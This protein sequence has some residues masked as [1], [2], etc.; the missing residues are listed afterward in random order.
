[1]DVNFARYSVCPE[2]GIPASFITLFCSGAVTSPEN[3]PSIQPFTARSSPASSGLALAGS[4]VPQTKK[5]ASGS[6]STLR[7]LFAV[8]FP[9]ALRIVTST[10][11]WRALALRHSGSAITTTRVDHSVCASARHKSGP[12]PAGSPAVITR[13]LRVVDITI[14]SQVQMRF[15]LFYCQMRMSTNASSRIRRIQ[16]CSSSDTLL[17]LMR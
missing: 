16:S 9:S 8:H 12:I 4:G 13:G 5:L 1:M 11:S 6:F 7:Q 3:C 14:L 10:S 2:N 17:F 15:L